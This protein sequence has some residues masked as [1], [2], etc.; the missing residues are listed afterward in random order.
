MRKILVLTIMM[1]FGLAISLQS[2]ENY[3]DGFNTDASSFS[4]YD[5][6]NMACCSEDSNCGDNSENMYGGGS[7]TSEDETSIPACGWNVTPNPDGTCPN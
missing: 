2:A 1:I 7:N 3:I 5:S 4:P 6:S